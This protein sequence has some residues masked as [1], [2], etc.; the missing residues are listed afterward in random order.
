MKNSIW[1]HSIAL[2]FIC[3]E[4]ELPIHSDIAKQMTLHAMLDNDNKVIVQLYESALPTDSL[5]LKY[6]YDANVELFENGN[7]ISTLVFILDSSHLFT[8]GYYTDTAIHIKP[9][10]VYTIKAT[11]PNFPS[12]SATDTIP[13]LATV[14]NT[15]VTGFPLLVL[16]IDSTFAQLQFTII[17][18]A[19]K[20]NVY[21]VYPY[22]YF[23]RYYKRSATDSV[24]IW[25]TS[26][27]Y[28]NA[29]NGIKLNNIYNGNQLD[30]VTFNGQSKS[31][32]LEIS[33]L[34]DS[35]TSIQ[36]AYI[37]IS[38]RQYSASYYLDIESKRKYYDILSNKIYEAPFWFYTNVIGGFGLLTS[39]SNN[40]QIIAKIK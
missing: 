39:T 3:C 7:K 1:I 34:Y 37:G 36:E 32:N 10:K 38:V 9:D 21:V 23:S 18:D 17:D 5:E 20:H 25:Q 6:I 29:I 30:D 22:Y 12:I 27:A 14:T 8:N 33:K 16:G 4:K 13:S 19:N 11:H 28:L 35:D 2:L 31:F 26:Y 24:L 15:S 40:N